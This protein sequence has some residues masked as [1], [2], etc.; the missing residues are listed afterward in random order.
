M[1][2]LIL[3]CSSILAVQQSKFLSVDFLAGRHL[4]RFWATRTGKRPLTFVTQTFDRHL[5]RKITW[6][7]LWWVHLL[8]ST[9]LV[10]ICQIRSVYCCTFWT[11]LLALD[12]F[13]HTFYPAVCEYTNIYRVGY[14]RTNVIGF[15]TSFVITFF[16]FRSSIH[17]NICI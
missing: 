12:R 7:E 14:A 15:G 6:A 1:S 17:L 11:E 10:K 5:Q 9:I 3:F 8:L 13:A 16:F 2:N 4:E